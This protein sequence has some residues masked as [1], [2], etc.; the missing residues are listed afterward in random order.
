[1]TTTAPHP[2]HIGDNLD[3]LPHLEGPFD[4]IYLD[5]PYNTGGRVVTGY[6]DRFEDWTGFMAPRLAHLPR[7][8]AEHGIVIASIDDREIHH[9]RVLLDDVLGAGNH[10]GTVVWD[11]STINSS[12]LLSVSHDYLVIYAKNHAALKASGTM[13]RQPRDDAQA[14][15]DAAATAWRTAA[16]DRAVAQQRFRAW[17]TPRRS[18]LPRG[19]TEYDRIDE[20][21]ALYRVGD[22]GAPSV[23]ASRSFRELTHPRT[24]LPCPVPK[25]G[26]R[27]NDA[28][29]D[30]MLETGLIEFGPD[31]T[32]QPKLKRMLADNATA[33][34]RSV[35]RQE[36]EG[37]RH[38]AGIDGVGEF[39]FPKDLAVLARWFDTVTGPDARIL[40]PFLGSGTSIEVAM[41]LNLADGGTR[42]VTGIAL[43]EGGIVQDVLVPRLRHCERTY[44]QTVSWSGTSSSSLAGKRP[45]R[46]SES[47]A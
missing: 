16:G 38:L 35:F 39:P 40:D 34:P 6:T 3:V 18:S 12:H 36:R 13:W 24:E 28:S 30:R 47:A 33:V 25:R 11:G 8:L 4:L 22:P 21:G 41:A 1:M 7:L 20:T 23:Q 5:P 17:L 42:Q 15:L 46:G 26:W 9:L 10:V 29:M 32:T 14:M 27:M 2:V 44:G 37:A 43:D 31:H 19:L 45:K